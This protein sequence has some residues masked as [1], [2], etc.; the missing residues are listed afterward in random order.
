[1]FKLSNPCSPVDSLSGVLNNL[2][3]STAALL[4]VKN[5]WHQVFYEEVIS[6]FPEEL[7]AVLYP[8]NMGRPNS[9]IRQLVGI[10]IL[11]EGHGWTDAQSFE[12][13]RFNLKVRWALGL[14]NLDDKVPSSSTY[15]TFRYNLHAYYK[16]TGIDLLEQA[17]EQI[18]KEQLE[19]YKI[20]GSN[21]RMDSKLYN[22]NIATSSL[23]RLI[24]ETIKVFLKDLLPVQQDLIDNSFSEL[25]AQIIKKSSD[26][27]SSVSYTHL[28]LPTILRV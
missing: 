3:P 12:E 16:S 13:I 10:M 24:A 27:I 6:S 28:T 20:N 25:V 1:M 4:Q 19:K 11:K 21:F 15:Y 2:D 26:G 9:P 8:S 14:R 17:F 23:C 5:S 7:F 22:S 18:S